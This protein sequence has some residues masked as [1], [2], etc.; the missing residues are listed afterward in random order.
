MVLASFHSVEE[1]AEDFA[2]A[3]RLLCHRE[4]STVLEDDM[5][6]PLIPATRGS[7]SGAVISS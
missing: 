5:L 2:V 1:E 7:T 6:G 4:V 3:F